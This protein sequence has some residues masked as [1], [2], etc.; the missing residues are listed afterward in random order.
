MCAITGRFATGTI[1]FGRV[2]VNGR[3]RAPCPPAITIAFR[4]LSSSVSSPIGDRPSRLFS[5]G[6]V[7]SL[8]PLP[9]KIIPFL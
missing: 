2:S 3:S 6:R 5:A 1:G 9:I 8:S 7:L 4:I